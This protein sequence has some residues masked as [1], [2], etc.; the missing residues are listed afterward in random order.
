MGLRPQVLVVSPYPRF[1]AY[2]KQKKIVSENVEVHSLADSD[3][4]LNRVVVCADL[5]MRLAVL[6]RS[7]VIVP[8]KLS[9]QDEFHKN[10]EDVTEEKIAKAAGKPR[11]F[12]I[13]EMV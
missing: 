12:K 3:N 10:P 13:V 4:V 6:A 2:L 5:P 8:L 11:R 1:V 9:L 7:V